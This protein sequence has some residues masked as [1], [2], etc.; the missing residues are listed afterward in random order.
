MAVHLAWSDAKLN[1]LAFQL[2]CFYTRLRHLSRI[3]DFLL[4]SENF[5]KIFLKK[6]LDDK[7][8]G[9]PCCFFKY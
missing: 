3:D 7:L 5:Y 9:L 4:K 8:S 6:K 1:F 2:L